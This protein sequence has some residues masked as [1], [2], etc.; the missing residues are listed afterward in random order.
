M[1]R[2]EIVFSWLLRIGV[3][4]STIVG[5]LGA[6]R[7]LWLYGRT[8]VDYGIFHGPSPGLDRIAT[9]LH[10]A[11]SGQSLAWVQFG[12]LLLLLTPVLRVLF[13]LIW[14]L[15]ERDWIFTV[16]TLYVLLTLLHSLLA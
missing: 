1:V 11:A 9:I 2:I 14:F 10:M 8:P 3:L 15:V 4:V 12:L 7:Q 6:C 16:A 5:G 13:S